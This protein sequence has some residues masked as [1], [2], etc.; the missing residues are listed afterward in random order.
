M[1]VLSGR[2]F[3]L[4]RIG[5]VR[6]GL[7]V[8]VSASATNRQFGMPIVIIK[9][10][11]KLGHVPSTGYYP[12][13]IIAAGAL[14][15]FRLLDAGLPFSWA[16]VEEG[17]LELNAS[18][19]VGSHELL[20][21]LD[22]LILEK[23]YGSAKPITGQPWPYITGVYPLENHLTYQ[24]GAKRYKQNFMLDPVDRRISLQGGS[25]QL[26]QAADAK[27]SMPRSETG[28]RYAF[29][30]P[31]GQL[32]TFTTGGKNSE[33]V[34]QLIRNWAD[35]NEAAE[36]YVDYTKHVNTQPLRPSFYPVAGVSWG[37]KALK[38]LES[39]GIDFYNFAAWS[40]MAR[41]LAATAKTKTHSGT[42]VPMSQHAYVG[43]P[44]DPSTWKLPLDEPGRIKNALSRVNQTHGIPQ[45]AKS[46]VLQ[47]IRH[48][49]KRIKVA[50]SK[51][52]TAGQ[53]AWEHKSHVNANM[54]GAMPMPGRAGHLG[55]PSGRKWGSGAVPTPLG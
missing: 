10:T 54:P 45:S 48:A 16:Y 29:A 34:T 50:I 25:Q 11:D 28:A 3:F 6:A 32:Q 12:S 27:T 38:A 42:P 1:F 26:I 24:V 55:S 8:E 49:A 18:E 22:S 14:T 51:K 19:V 46:G 35:I 52:P 7:P 44:K 43:D 17:A 53:K 4:A 31:M 2:T 20:T 33:L 37:G 15:R 30:P 40:G 13:G 47:K 9:N 23:V 39:R 21:R 36:M 41:H 5:L